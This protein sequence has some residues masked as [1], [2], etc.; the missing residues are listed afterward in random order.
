MNGTMLLGIDSRVVEHCTDMFTD[1]LFQIER[2]N[3]TVGI[4]EATPKRRKVKPHCNQQKKY[5]NK[6]FKNC[7]CM[8]KMKMKIRVHIHR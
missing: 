8:W 2:S 6:T 7:C 1:K 3:I 4:K 5:R